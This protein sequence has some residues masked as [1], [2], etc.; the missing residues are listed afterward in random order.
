MWVQMRYVVAKPNKDGSKRW[1]WQRLGFP[2]R[3]LPD[4]ETER[5]KAA[6]QL[7]ARADAKNRTEP[8][9]PEHGT[10]TAV[11]AWT[12]CWPSAPSIA[13]WVSTPKSSAPRRSPG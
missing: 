11:G 13:I 12:S 2:T 8:V 5:V 10:I 1:Y 6:G 3:R 9:E 4:D 7:N